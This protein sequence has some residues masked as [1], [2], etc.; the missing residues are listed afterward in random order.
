[1]KRLV[2][3]VSVAL[4]GFL[5]PVLAM[6]G[7]RLLAAAKKA[8]A[9]AE[10][11]IKDRK[12]QGSNVFR[13]TEGQT[14]ELRWT[15]DETA[16]LHLHGYD[17]EVKAKPGALATMTFKAHATGRYPVTVH[18]FGDSHSHGGSHSEQTLYYVEVHPK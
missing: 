13:V 12:L 6:D 18:G 2:V 9:V 15:T 3:L 14:V 17:I 8:D 16:E 11:T 5:V 10:L 1:M 7:S 4:L